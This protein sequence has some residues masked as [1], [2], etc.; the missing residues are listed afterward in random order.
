MNVSQTYHHLRQQLV[1]TP[2]LADEATAITRL[3]FD[4]YLHYSLTDIAIRGDFD[5]PEAIAEIM[6]EALNRIAQGEPV[7]YV[8]GSE[9]FHGLR[10]KVTPATLIPRPE[11]EQ[12]VDIIIDRHKHQRGLRVLDVGTGSG[13]IAIALARSLDWAE[14]DAIDFSADALAVAKENAK[15]LKVNVNFIH[16]DILKARAEDFEKYDIIVSNPPYV[17]MSE[18]AQMLP[19]VLEHEPHSALFVPDS[20]PLLFYRAITRFAAKALCEGGTLYFETNTAFTTQVAQLMTA[21]GFT[22][23]ETH[24]DAFTHPRFAIAKKG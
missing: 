3:L 2:G 16:A 17:T 18:K 15:A 9:T 19:N 13:C 20:D 5:V 11:T 22:D 24:R 7:Q 1:D 14:V 10:F 8:I 4:H 23:A 12:L 6:Q 21:E